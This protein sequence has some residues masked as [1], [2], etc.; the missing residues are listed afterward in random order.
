[1]KHFYKLLTVSLI[2][3][4]LA[5]CGGGGGK[6]ACTL[7]VGGLAC[8]GSGGSSS[9]SSG[10]SSSSVTSTYSIYKSMNAVATDATGPQSTLVEVNGI[11]YGTTE[12]GGS[13]NLGTVFSVNSSLQI[14][15]IHSFAGGTDGA[16]PFASLVVA[17]DGNLWGT[18]TNGGSSNYGTVFKIALSSGTPT[19]SQVHVFLSSNGANPY[20]GLIQGTGTDT[21]FYGTTSL[22][23]TSNL[24]TVYKITL[25]GQESVIYSFDGTNGSNPQSTLIKD[26]NGDMYG[27]TSNGGLNSTGT[28]FKITTSG[29]PTLLYTFGTNANDGTN[30]EGSL[31]LASDGKLYGTTSTGGL[32][33]LGT[34]FSLSTSGANYQV[35]HAF[36]GPTADGSKPYGNLVEI[37]S[38]IYGTTQLG[39]SYDLGSI[40]S[41]KPTTGVFSLIHSFGLLSDGSQPF[42][43]LVLGSDGYYYGTTTLGGSNS[44][45]TVYKFY[46]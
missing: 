21:A 34:L 26:S 44:T 22:G 8:L 18:T 5:A 45:G 17:R 32:N 6:A 40:Y 16:N 3:F 20:G 41:L 15:V 4:I 46:P 13:A 36:A 35:I 27:T 19:Y 28:V 11:F 1:M 9:G 7:A 10:G 39:G 31:L 2:C 38:A 30:P 33:S 23:G 29:V 37:S 42:A 24:G 14:T 43:G 12:S 25:L